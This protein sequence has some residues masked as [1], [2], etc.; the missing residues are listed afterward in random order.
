MQSCS[1]HIASLIRVVGNCLAVILVP[2]FFSFCLNNISVHDR[3]EIDLLGVLQ[4]NRGLDKSSYQPWV[5]SRY[6]LRLSIEKPSQKGK[7]K[8]SYQNEPWT[9]PIKLII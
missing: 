6:Q 5:V 1:D 3:V 4:I 7:E 9:I 8:L 2:E